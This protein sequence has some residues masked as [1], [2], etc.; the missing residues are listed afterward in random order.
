MSCSH[1]MWSLSFVVLTLGAAIGACGAAAQDKQSRTVEQ[2]TCKEIMR[3]TGEQRRAAIAFL[4]GFFVGKSGST[5]LNLGT[6]AKQTD[7]F[8]NICLDNPKQKAMEAM[9]QAKS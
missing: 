6:M 3:E 4:H 1:R 7:A 5:K 9:K 8:V 2:F